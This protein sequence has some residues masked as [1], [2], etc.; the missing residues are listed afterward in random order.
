MHSP[1]NLL[2]R[3]HKWASRQDENFLTEAFV[4]LLQHLPAYEAEAGVRLIGRLTNGVIAESADHAKAIEIR[5]QVVSGEGTPDI[6]IRT[7]KAFGDRG[8]KI[9]IRTTC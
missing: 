6:S 8:G 1:N 3:L 4:H 9:G 7:L 2:V 5:P